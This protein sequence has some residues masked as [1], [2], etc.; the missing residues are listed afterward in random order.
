MRWRYRRRVGS[1]NREGW[2][3]RAFGLALE[4]SLGLECVVETRPAKRADTWLEKVPRAEVDRRWR[5][6]APRTV[7]ER[8]LTDGRVGIS[9]ERDDELGFRVWAPRHGCYLIAADGR[10]VLCAPPSGP[11]WRWERLVLA[12]VLPLAAVLRGKDVLHASAVA[13]NGRAVAFLGRSGAGKTTLAGRIVAHGPSLVTDDVLAIDLS[14]Q[15]VVVHRGAG[16]ARIDARELRAMTGRERQVLGAVLARGEKCHVSPPLGP[17][18]LPLALTYHLVRPADVG[19]VD[20]AA[21][22]PDDPGLLLGNA[23]LPYVNDPERLRRLLDVC[24]EVAA[25]TP[26]YEVRVGADTASADVAAAVLRHVEATLAE[27]PEP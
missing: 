10:R 18:R 1:G 16:V 20:I 25:T 12:Q 4:G 5:A 23:F 9:V 15:D 21:V 3:G 27:Q 24:A 14:G 11:A 22:H 8:R 6:A 2:S 19:G 13:V 26:L 7:F 17:L